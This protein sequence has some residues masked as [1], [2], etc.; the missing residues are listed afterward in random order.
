MPRNPRK[1]PSSPAPRFTI[2]PA[3]PGAALP[4][5]FAGR[6]LRWARL[7]LLIGSPIACFLALEILLMLCGFGYPTSFFL[8]TRI[9]RQDVLVQNDRF[10][11]RFMGRDLARQPFPLA[12][13]VSKAPGTVRIFVLGESAAYGDPQPEFGLP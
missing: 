1:R 2:A 10:T 6:S 8:R 12:V 3:R 5:P 4:V 9:N 11:W 7:G 13:P